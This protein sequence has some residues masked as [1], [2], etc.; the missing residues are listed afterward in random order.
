L[1]HDGARYDR[2]PP[3][4]VL[5][6]ARRHSIVVAVLALLLVPTAWAAGKERRLSQSDVHVFDGNP[7]EIYAKNHV[8]GAMHLD[9][10][11]IKEGVLPADKSSTLIFYCMSEL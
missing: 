9:T 4:E 11:D 8:P 6:R 2:A 10:E 7:P 5:M 3:E 1:G